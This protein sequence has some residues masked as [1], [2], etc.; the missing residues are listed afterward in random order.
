LLLKTV[1]NRISSIVGPGDLAARLGGDEFA[2][3]QRV[4]RNP[5]REAL[6]LADR[7][8]TAISEGFQLEEQEVK[9]GTSIGIANAPTHGTTASQLLQ[10]A[11]L[12]LYRAKAAGRGTSITFEQGMD[13]VVQDQ[14][15]LEM[16]LRFALQRKEF[17]LHYQP[18]ISL[19]SGSI[20]GFE[21]LVRWRHPQLGLI[22]PDRFIPLAEETGVI[23]ELGDWVLERG[24]T[25]ALAWPDHIKLA[26]NLSP[27]QLRHG[28]I[29]ETVARV[30]ETSCLSPSRLELEVTESVMLAGD[31]SRQTLEK[32]RS[33]GISTVL[34]DFGTG[35]ASLSYLAQM[36][37]S[38]IK[39]DRS[40]VADLPS[41]PASRAIV[42][43][44][45]NLA[46]E[47]D[48]EIT[49]EGIETEE[50][51]LLVKAA[52]CT[53]AQGYLFARPKPFAQLDCAWEGEPEKAPPKQTLLA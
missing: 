51:L 24:I 44:V 52:G 36:P 50:Q 19:G 26:I 45:A 46:R 35:Y 21:A 29:I 30:L 28:S 27:V 1:A 9:I 3:V 5:E 43:A 16:D 20:R 40:F 6:R 49:A 42:G 33:L 14:H 18:F 48:M 23:V 2:I 15:A 47:L 4:I 10:N 37:F 41:H 53:D 39:I 11:D 25:D 8:L 7:L 32:L 12:A 34:D 31:E 17:E 38:K 13:M 22:P